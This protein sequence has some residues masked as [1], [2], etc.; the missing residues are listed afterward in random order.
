MTH[1][2][3]DA[4]HKDLETIRA[5]MGLLGDES[6]DACKAAVKCLLSHAVQGLG[7]RV[8]FLVV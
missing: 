8:V 6:L 4:M 2:L 7:L 5:T 3:S 1:G